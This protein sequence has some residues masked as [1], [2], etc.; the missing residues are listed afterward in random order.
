MMRQLQ[1]YLKRAHF[2]NMAG[3]R[4]I[5]P[6][7][8]LEPAGREMFRYFLMLN[9]ELAYHAYAHSLY[10]SHFSLFRLFAFAAFSHEIRFIAFARAMLRLIFT[11]R[12]WSLVTRQYFAPSSIYLGTKDFIHWRAPVTVW[13]P[14]SARAHF[15]Q[16]FIA[17]TP[18][19]YARAYS[20]PFRAEARSAR[21]A[22]AD[23][24]S[25]LAGLAEAAEYL[26]DAS[27]CIIHRRRGDIKRPFRLTSIFPLRAIWACIMTCRHDDYCAADASVYH[28]SS[29][30]RFGIR[31]IV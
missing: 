26:N 6:P 10:F 19:R 20:R 2:G 8:K 29:G 31:P 3:R 7:L 15:A 12:S 23:Y 13:C 11:L 28:A 24:I 30:R 25:L 27:C 21:A 22:T 17:N 5:S 9:S 14:L 18:S 4:G 1:L 16:S